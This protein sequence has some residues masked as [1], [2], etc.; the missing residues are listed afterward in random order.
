MK[1]EQ[2]QKLIAQ[3]ANAKTSAEVRTVIDQAISSGFN[4]LELLTYFKAHP[5]DIE[6]KSQDHQNTISNSQKAEIVIQQLMA[7]LRG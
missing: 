2:L 1:S 4:V 3:L 6:T 7:K 5:R